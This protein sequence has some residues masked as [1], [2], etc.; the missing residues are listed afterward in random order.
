MA[1]VL[2]RV[3]GT[4]LKVAVIGDEDTVAGF[5]MAGIGMRDGLGRTNFFVVD[6]KTKR[7]DIEEAFRTMTE[8]QDIGILL[9]NQHVADDIRYMVD[10][11]TKIIPTILEIPSKDKPYDPSKDSVMQ[12]IKFFFG[13][14]LPTS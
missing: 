5:L 1:P 8:R 7:Q 9:I 2:G 10:L 12:R 14:E 11:H 13:G 6:S 3:Q 4:D